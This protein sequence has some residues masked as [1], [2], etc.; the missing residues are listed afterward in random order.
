MMTTS[1]RAL[2]LLIVVCLY[3]AGRIEALRYNDIACARVEAVHSGEYSFTVD[4]A[5]QRV[6][7]L[8]CVGIAASTLALL[9]VLDV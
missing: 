7:A 6:R 3:G 9:M 4:I 2:F 8:R 1:L 5:V